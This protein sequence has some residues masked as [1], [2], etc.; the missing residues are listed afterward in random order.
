[1][2]AADDAADRLDRYWDE[3]VRGRAVHPGGPNA[4]G[5]EGLDPRLALAVR[6]LHAEDDAPAPDAGFAAR[7]RTALGLAAEA[8]PP[9][10]TSTVNTA[11]AGRLRVLPGDGVPLAQVAA[12][13]AIALAILGGRLLGFGDAPVPTVT[14][15]PAAATATAIPAVGDGDGCASA[16][17]RDESEAAGTAI[18]PGGEPIKRSPTAPAAACH[19]TP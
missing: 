15:A 1:M 13:A 16:P 3:V 2:R 17:D 12:A 18:A 11:R 10:L 8:T 6:R 14:A 9:A 7:L 5:P 19:S 4:D